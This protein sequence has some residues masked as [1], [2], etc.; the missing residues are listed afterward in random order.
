M[1]RPIQPPSSPVL[2]VSALNSLARAAVENALP[3]VWVGGEISNLT[4]A[5]S[6][7]WYFSLKDDR[8]QV[9]CAM[10]RGRNQFVDWQPVN[11]DQVDSLL[12]LAFAS[13][14]PLTA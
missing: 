2:T 6:G 10:F 14:P 13:A 1:E 7:H 4:R 3:L 5:A 11:G 12:R 8:A 9:R